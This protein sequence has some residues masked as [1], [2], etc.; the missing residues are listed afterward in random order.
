MLPSQIQFWGQSICICLAVLDVACMLS[1]WLQ[2]HTVH[3][4][5]MVTV[6]L[7][8]GDC[9]KVGLVVADCLLCVT[10]SQH[11][12]L[13]D[14]AGT[15]RRHLVAMSVPRALLSFHVVP[16]AAI[17]LATVWCR[18]SCGDISKKASTG[19]HSCAGLGSTGS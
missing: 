18:W 19:F 10:D 1:S 6:F 17:T 13:C 9:G 14:G 8:F 16:S 5:S 15:L 4:C 11:P 7:P 3:T 2:H 12:A